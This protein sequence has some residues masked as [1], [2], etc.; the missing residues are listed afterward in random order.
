L[1]SI[2][3]SSSSR[4]AVCLL[5]AFTS[6]SFADTLNGSGVSATSTSLGGAVAA[7]STQPLDMMTENPANLSRVRSRDLS[8][9][10]TT[11]FTQGS[12]SNA[13]NSNAGINSFA[14]AVPFGAF[15]TPLGSSRFKLGFSVT[16]EMALAAKW[17]YVD[18]PGGLGGTSY[19]LQD[20][21]SS[22]LALRSAVG[23]GFAVSKTLSFGFTAGMVYN[24]NSLQTPFVFQTQPVLAGFKTLVDLHTTGI[25]WNESAGVTWSPTRKFQFGAAYKTRTLIHSH[26]D[27]SGNAG[28]QLATIGAPFRPDFHYNAQVDNVLPQTV[29]AGASWQFRKRMRLAL[30]TDWINWD[31]AFVSL[32]ITLTNGNNADINGFVGSSTLRDEVPLHWHNQTVLRAGLETSLTE[33]MTLRTGY[34][35]SNNPVPAETVMPLTAAMVRNTFASG[36]GYRRG[37]YGVDATYQFQ[38]PTSEHVGQSALKAGEFDNSR[39]EVAMHIVTVTTSIHF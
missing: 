15:V 30:Q 4:L 9:G 29:I 31:K 39:V 36:M 8:L 26:G 24:S 6:S 18:A 5:I 12:F 34:S 19:G 22:I 2:G 37:R 35:F 7:S 27:L 10:A 14:G 21:R 3:R 28:A 13:S 32:P 38:P 25:G 11:V 16:P 20:N 23:V 17:R 1:N 33:R